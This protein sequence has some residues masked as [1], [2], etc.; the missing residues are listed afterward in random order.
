VRGPAI[1]E[2]W[3]TMALGVFTAVRRLLKGGIYK[4][5]GNGKV[6]MGPPSGFSTVTYVQLG[7]SIVTSSGGGAGWR[8]HFNF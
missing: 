5:F 4:T 2:F 7:F 8:T 6:E 3:T 1:F